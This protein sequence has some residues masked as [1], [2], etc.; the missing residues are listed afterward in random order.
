[1]T[2][3]IKFER[4][5]IMATPNILKMFNTISV[6][7][8]LCSFLHFVKLTA[9]VPAFLSLL[10]TTERIHF[11]LTIS[12]AVTSIFYRSSSIYPLSFSF[13][14]QREVAF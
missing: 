6:Y 4:N 10:E 11:T 3:F 13:V 5:D 7:K 12:S 1:M 2:M 8:V 14:E 9:K